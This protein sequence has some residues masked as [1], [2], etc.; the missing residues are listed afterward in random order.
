MPNAQCRMPNAQRLTP[1]PPFHP[2]FP[3]GT[4]Q[5]Q[6]LQ[7]R[8]RPPVRKTAAQ[9]DPRMKRMLW[10]TGL[11]VAC[12]AALA[13]GG[14]ARAGK[15]AAVSSTGRLSLMDARF[16]QAAALGDMMEIDLGQLAGEKA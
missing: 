4:S 6:A 5:H 14:P 8:F 3:P 7:P 11:I 15:D 16:V 2:P 12:A 1:F 13:A 9:E 10:L